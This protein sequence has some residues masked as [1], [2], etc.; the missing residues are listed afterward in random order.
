MYF[1]GLVVGKASTIGIEM[2]PT[3]P[4]I[5][6]GVKECEIWRCFQHHSTSR[7]SRLK[8]QQDIPYLKQISCVRMI[9]LCL[10]QVCLSWVHA[11]LR[12]AQ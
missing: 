11:P 1:R 3:P 12:I 6:R 9:A 10:Y 2:S 7:R 4:L 5:F 8:M